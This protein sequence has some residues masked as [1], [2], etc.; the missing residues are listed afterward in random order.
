MKRQILFVDDEPN[1]L[2]GLQRSLRPMR[3]YWDMVFSQGGSNALK[4]LEKQSFDVIVSDMRMPEMDGARLLKIVQEK[5]PLMVRIILSGHSDREMIM[6]SVKSAHQYLSKPCEKQI[7]VT[8]ITRSCSLRDLLNKKA[9]QQ[10]LGGIETMPSIPSLYAKII[11]ELQSSD[12]S[13]ASVGEII[14]KDMGMTA[15]VL[16]LVNSSFFGMP[17][18]ISN[19]QEAVVLLG[20]DIV[21]TLVLGI[22]VFSRFSKNALSII[23]V[24]KIHDHCVKTGVIA[25]KIAKLEK[26]DKEKT[27]NAM[28]ASSLHDLGKLILVEHYPD[29]YKGVLEVVRQ[30]KMPVFKAESQIFG[31]THGEVG[32]YLLG[33]WGLPENIIEGIAFHHNPAKINT[34]EFELCGLV[35]VAELMEHHE[36]LQPGGWEKLNGLDTKYMENIG[37]LDKIP[38]WRD[39]L[40]IK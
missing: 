25:K 9:L 6:K 21:K 34:R 1:I 16:Q 31:V 27:D 20:I 12:A 38:L 19:V 15:K 5:Y 28:I 7:L 17:R 30:K 39:Y 29:E 24:D 2:K 35:H 3:K 23:P 40:R 36:Q 22:E 8:T 26:M 4:L 11:S 14:A 18:H 33:L 10:L 13:A 37:L 32:A